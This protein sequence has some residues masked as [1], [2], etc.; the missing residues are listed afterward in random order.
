L[1][2]PPSVGAA[3]TIDMAHYGS[4]LAPANS[5]GYVIPAKRFSTAEG[6]V[7]SE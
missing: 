5:T 6:L 4:V 3:M 2:V 1:S 7:K